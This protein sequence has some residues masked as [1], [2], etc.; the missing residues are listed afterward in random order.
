[1]VKAWVPEISALQRTPQPLS[2]LRIALQC[3]GSD[4]FSGVSGNPLAGAMT[5]TV[6]REGG[7][8]VLCETD[9]VNGGEA[10]LMRNM[11]DLA[12]AGAL[13]SRIAKFKERMSWHGVTPEANPSAG[14]KFRGLYN[15]ALK[16]LG[17]VQKKDPRTRVDHVTDYAEPLTAPGF[18]FMD[19]PGN[20]LE[21]IAGQ[22]AAGCNL[23]LFVTGNGSITNFPFVPTLKITTTTRRHQLLE[24]EMDINAGRYLDGEAFETLTQDAIDLLIETASGTPTKGEKAGHYQTS[25]W[26]DWRQTNA[27]QLAT[28]REQAAPDGQP[29]PLAFPVSSPSPDPTRT[30]AVGLVLPTS[31]CSSQI[32]RM[33]IEQMNAQGLA[34]ELGL[35]RFV[36]L[37]HS[38]GCGFGGAEMER[39]LHRAFQGYATHPNVAAALLLEHGCEKIPNDAMRRQFEASGIPLDRFGWASVQLDGGIE[40]TLRRIE[41]WFREHSNPSDLAKPEPA[42]EPAI[43]NGI[44]LGLLTMGCPPQVT[45][46]TLSQLAK[47]VLS[48]GGSVLIPETD[49]LLSNPRFTAPLLGTTE[50]RATLA[51]AEALKIPGFHVV[52]TETDHW[53]ENIASLGAGGLHLMVGWVG[54]D[55]QTGHPLIPVIQIAEPGMT[56]VEVDLK[57]SRSNAAERWQELVPL[58]GRT[59][60]GDHQPVADKTGTVDFQFTRGWLGVSA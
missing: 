17:A 3:G 33:A 55:T 19:S 47:E 39:S 56:V 7:I 58:L 51:N 48:R 16:S 15:I 45:A 29:L 23:I 36:A 26:R 38:E 41:M 50:A 8:G 11:R 37:P 43:P 53:T 4:A 10:H 35:S 1:M 27:R 28:L 2:E 44:N 20:D 40:R 49:S 54:E 30:E 21:A 60:A 14:N 34:G 31:L 46:E 59:L 52:R 32:T 42:A 22:V 5:H 12:T 57:F 18:Y 13:L 25:I 24:R 6:V 9:E